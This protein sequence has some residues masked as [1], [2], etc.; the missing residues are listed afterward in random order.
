VADSHLLR[1]ILAHLGALVFIYSHHKVNM[2]AWIVRE[3]FVLLYIMSDRSVESFEH[4][5]DVYYG[6]YSVVS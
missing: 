4:S 5:K 3:C 1:E 2:S 6:K